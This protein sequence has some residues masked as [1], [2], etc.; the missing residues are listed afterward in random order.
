[1]A[2][3][4]SIE[5]T[6]TTWNPVV[7]CTKVSAGCKNCYAEKMACRLEAIALSMIDEGKN[8]GR[9]ANYIG[10]INAHRH[11]NGNIHLDHDSVE[12]PYRWKKPRL[13]FVNS[14]SDLF[15]EKVPLDF[16]QNVFAVMNNLPQHTFQVLTKRPDI[17]ADYA[18]CL[19]W[20]PNI[21]MGTSVEDSRYTHRVHELKIIPAAVK[22]LSIEP[23]LGPIPRLPLS[24]V[25]WVIVGGESG[26]GAREVR[27]E[28]VRQI[29][30]KCIARGVPFFFKQWGGVKKK[31]TGR[32]LDGRTWNQMPD[33]YKDIL[34]Y[35]SA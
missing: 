4:S 24:G 29:R 17:A 10:T 5:W 34:N 19:D 11:W 20:S 23:L 31:Q 15:Q 3:N 22:F 12:E 35:A 6:E 2:S 30:D 27:P 14:M 9:A 26:P 21:W 8:P 13:V 1:M 16:I 7:G 18:N 25:D 33:S 32:T 28:W